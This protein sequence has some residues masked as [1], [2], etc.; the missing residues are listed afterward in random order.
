M[1]SGSSLSAASKNTR[2]PSA[3]D[4]TEASV[5]G[6]VVSRSSVAEEPQATHPGHAN[7]R[8][9]PC[10]CLPPPSL[11]SVVKNTRAPSAE[12]PPKPASVSG[13]GFAD[14]SLRSRSVRG[15]GAAETTATDTNPATTAAHENATSTRP[16]TTRRPRFTRSTPSPHM[17]TTPLSPK[18]AHSQD[19]RP[20][21]ILPPPPPLRRLVGDLATEHNLV[22]PEWR[23]SQ[24]A[25][26]Q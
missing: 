11:S 6:R 20:R 18:R 23:G 24:L 26:M 3:R 8:R 17:Q 21:A 2:V 5:V 9:R 12:T 19:A 16:H 10:R 7:R 4:T 1:S 25:G 15:A 13:S 22:R 14:P